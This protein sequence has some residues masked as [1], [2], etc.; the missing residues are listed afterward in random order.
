MKQILSCK[1]H[2]AIVSP[3]DP[4]YFV[5]SPSKSTVGL[6]MKHCSD[7]QTEIRYFQR[8]LQIK[9]LVRISELEDVE[10]AA[11][12]LLLGGARKRMVTAVACY[13]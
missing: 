5:Y 10:E 11:M 7:S 4:F 13:F 12:S 8:R 3:K 9:P 6:W 1:V 2:G